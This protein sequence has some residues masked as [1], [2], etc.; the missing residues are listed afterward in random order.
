MNGEKSRQKRKEKKACESAG[1]N[2]KIFKAA[3][4]NIFTELKK[5]LISEV[6]YDNNVTLN[7]EHQEREPNRNS[8]I[9][10]CSNN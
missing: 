2:M 3:I 8:E 6:N 7:R 5:S 9:E 10:Q 4:I 1:F